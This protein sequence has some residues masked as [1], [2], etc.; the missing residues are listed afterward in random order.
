MPLYIVKATSSHTLYYAIRT[1]RK[2]NELEAI[3]NEKIA[4]GTLKDFAQKWEGEKIDHVTRVTDDKFISEFNKLNIGERS[5]SERQK[6]SEIQN[7][8]TKTQVIE[9]DEI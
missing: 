7:I 1:E 5:W 4:D 6:L 3:V 2:R 8:D 9:E